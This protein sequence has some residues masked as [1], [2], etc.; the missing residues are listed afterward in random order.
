MH[1][2]ANPKRFLGLAQWLTPLCL[3]LGLLLTTGALAWG[4]WVVPPD[5]LM[6]ETVRILF[7]HVPFAWLGM[8]GWMGI[9]VAASSILSGAIRWRLAARGIAVPELFYCTLPRH[10]SIGAARCGTGGWRR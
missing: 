9:A 6:D 5:R 2:F 8:G 3:G 10:R 7:L 4:F 1:A